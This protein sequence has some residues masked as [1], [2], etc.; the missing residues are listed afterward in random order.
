MAK[1]PTFGDGRRRG[2]RMRTK[3]RTARGRKLSSTRWLE[4]QLNDPYVAAAKKDGYRSRAAYKIIEMDDRFKLFAP[5]GC[6]ID[7]GSAPGG[8]SQIAAQRVGSSAQNGSTQKGFVGAIDIQDMEPIAGVEFIKLD[9]LDDSAPAAVRELAGRRADAVISDMAAPVTG[10]RQTDHLRTMALAEAAAWFSFEI[11]RP[12][13]AFCAKVFQGGASGDL[14][15]E[16]K[17]R[18]GRVHHMKPKSSRKESVELYVIALDFKG[19][20]GAQHGD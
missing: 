10:H 8:W 6:V 16:L 15:A 12:G 5:G 11:L 2:D 17:R 13:G 18:F 19:G 9:F 14:L 1:P 20:D 7:L 3:L 4:R